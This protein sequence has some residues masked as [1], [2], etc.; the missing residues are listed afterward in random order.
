MRKLKDIQWWVFGALVLSALALGWLGFR[1]YFAALGESRSALDL[2]YLALQLF[3]LE[4]GA[5]SGPVPWSLEVARLL[6]PALAGYA[7]ARAVAAVFGEQIQNIRARMSRRHVVVCGMGRKGFR[8]AGAF[9]ERGRRVV[10][11]EQ[12]QDNSGIDA[13]RELGAIVLVGSALD[14]RVLRRARADRADQLVFVCG[15][16]GTSAEAAVLAGN[17]V[18]EGRQTPTG[19]VHLFNPQ[20]IRLLRERVLG[21]QAPLP[22]RLELFN[23]FERG[24][25]ALLADHP[26]GNEMIVV[27]VGRLGESLIAEAARQH[28]LAPGAGPLR[29]TIVDRAAEA[30]RALLPLRY[31]GIGKSCTIVAQQMEVGSARFEQA[32]FLSP[33]ASLYVC[34][35][36]DQASLSAGLVMLRAAGDRDIPVVVRMSTSRQAGLA[37][38]LESP[39]EKFTKLHVFSVLD[40]ACRLDVLLAGINEVLARAIHEDYARK[41]KERGETPESNPS[42][43]AWDRLP[44]HLKESNRNQADGIGEKLR[45]AG[46]RIVPLDDWDAPL[47][48]FSDDEVEQLARLEHDRWVADRLRTGWTYSPGPKDV[49]K[50]TSPY[51]IPYDRLTEEIKDLDRNTVRELPAFLARAGYSLAPIQNRRE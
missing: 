1:A 24:A 35:D 48:V 15:D 18:A 6:A 3:V 12:D 31:P 46:Y 13:I 45:T 2:F 49:E 9:L 50:K 17:L 8:L 41:Q 38:L 29:I 10:V 20:L 22:L 39:G 7:V 30:K 51:L 28:R 32:D 42:M 16:D 44:E 14:R 4:S 37:A 11:I 19:Y 21:G 40:H 27:G 36:D 43:V 34:L 33:G 5:V 26:P 23:V 47:S 25:R